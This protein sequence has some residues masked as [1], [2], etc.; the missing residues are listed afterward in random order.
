MIVIPAI[1]VREGKV[2]RLRH[3]R[4]Q[5]M[6][7]YADDPV[8]TARGYAA[9]GARQVHVVDLDAAF[10][11][12]DNRAVIA[13]VAREA[14]V[15]IQVGGGLRSLLLI[16]GVLAVGAS[17]VVLGTE[18]ILDPAFL[19]E[20]VER[21]GQRVVVALDTDGDVVKVRGWT[22]PAGSFDEILERLVRARVPRLLV[23][24]IARDGTL[25]GPDLDLYRRLSPLGVPVLASGGVS[26]LEDLR[27]LARA[28]VEG[29]VVGK[30]L[31]E[32]RFTLREAIEVPV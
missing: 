3:G 20:C 9:D 23:T 12:G 8:E 1:D 2:V 11:V 29:A 24:A 30:A 32:G 31:Y 4:L 18:A 17:R 21:Y 10:G 19:A 14:G 5:E 25:E 27:R 22:E 26:S 7:V 15:P 13:E 16:E 6:I 28:G